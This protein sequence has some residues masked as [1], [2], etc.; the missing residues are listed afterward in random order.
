MEA[1][2]DERVADK[3][4]DTVVQERDERGC[5]VSSHKG[6]SAPLRTQRNQPATLTR[7]IHKPPAAEGWNDDGGGRDGEDS[8]TGTP[9]QDLDGLRNVRK[10]ATRIRAN[11]LRE[12]AGVMEDVFEM[13]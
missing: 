11:V 12:L 7:N 2:K 4:Q 5:L 8:G 9:L 1:R 3:I 6:R 13:K 10:L